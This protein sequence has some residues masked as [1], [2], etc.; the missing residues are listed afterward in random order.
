M[1]EQAFDVI[2]I[3]LGGMGA[4]ASY[5][6]AR[7]G[8][9]VLGLEQFGIPHTLGSSHGVNRII[10]LAYYEDPSYV[11]LLRRAFELWRE[12]EAALGEQLL[13]VTGSIDC[14]DRD[15]YVFTE[16][17]RSCEL[18]DLP[19]EVLNAA[20]IMD[21]WPAFQ[22][23]DVYQAVYQPDGGYVMSERAIVAHIE[24]AMAAGAEIHGFEPVLSWTTTSSGVEVKTSRG[25]Y[26]ASQIVLSAGAWMGDLVP[27]L[28]GI[29]QP[30]R[31]VLGWFWPSNPEQFQDATLPVF[32]L[33]G[34]HERWYGFP[35]RQIPGFKFGKYHHRHEPVDPDTYDRNP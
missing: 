31:Q 25:T 30:E 17:L 5:H 2:V 22:L 16:S 29:L 18:H 21:R 20:Q 13:H 1:A 23:P 4:A 28:S 7:R 14:A 26:V 10:R 6:L 34:E 9:R 33:A 3:G 15:H 27:Q 35:M 12:T 8:L 11:P 24:G 19:H 32:N